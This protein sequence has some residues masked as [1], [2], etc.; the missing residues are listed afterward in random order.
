MT[1]P[2][3]AK[4]R[5]FASQR[6]VVHWARRYDL[7]VSVFTL[8][9][10]GRLRRLMLDR[11]QIEPGESVLDVGCGTGTLAIAAVRRV[12]GTGSVSGIDASPEM[13][14]RARAKAARAGVTVTFDVAGAEALPF[15]DASFDVVLSTV[16]LH[17]LRRDARAACMREIRRVL[18]PGGRVLVVDFGV[19][20]GQRGFFAH[21][22]RHGRVHL[23]DLVALQTDAGITVA[24]SGNLGF[25][26]LLY[27][28]GTVE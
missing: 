23:R 13:I 4:P 27:V 17:H 25:G 11:A 18:A 24:D 6:G 2:L 5:A 19:N 26:T 14:S 15:P 21:V 3:D 7:L 16:M 10:E 1:T 8:G 22:H 12:R 20:T 9:R 28:L